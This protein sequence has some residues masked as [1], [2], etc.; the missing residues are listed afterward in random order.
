M[1]R[2]L[3]MLV[4]VWLFL[5]PGNDVFAWHVK[6][7][8]KG[9]TESS[10]LIITGKVTHIAANIEII[11]NQKIVFTCVTLEPELVLQG[12]KPGSALTIK[13]VGGLSGER[14]TWHELYQEFNPGEEVLVF[15]HPLDKRNNVWEMKSISSKLSVANLDGK[16]KYDCSMLYADEV[17]NYD[18][19]VFFEKSVIIDRINNYL[20]A[21]KGGK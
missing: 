15:L 4:L 5:Q 16:Q 10:P 6:N 8:L 18:N 19:N 17:S 11:N 21:K 7:T 12:E 2:L 1:K 14:G 13:M 9:L 20:Q 3:Y